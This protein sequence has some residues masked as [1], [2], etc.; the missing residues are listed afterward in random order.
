VRGDPEKAA[1]DD[2]RDGVGRISVEN[3]LEP[4]SVSR[5]LPGVSPMHMDQDIDIGKVIPALP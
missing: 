2:I 1:Q 4:I 5:M 3:V